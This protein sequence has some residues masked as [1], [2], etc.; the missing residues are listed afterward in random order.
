MLTSEAIDVNNIP[1]PIRATFEPLV[2]ELKTQNEKLSQEEFLV[3]CEQIY[4]V[5]I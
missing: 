2:N 1:E 5:S 4:I 3:A